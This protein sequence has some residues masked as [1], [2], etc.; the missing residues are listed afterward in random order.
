MP[1]YLRTLAAIIGA[2][3]LAVTTLPVMAQGSP[4]ADPPKKV[5]HAKKPKP[6]QAKEEYLRAAGSEPPPK[7][8]K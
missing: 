7:A 3:F 1:G 6:P 5:K 4:P 2:A 8:T